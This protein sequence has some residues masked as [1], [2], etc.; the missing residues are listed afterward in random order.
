MFSGSLVAIVT[1]MR[2]DGAVDFA[3]W[4]RLAR[5]SPRRTAPTASSSGARRASRPPQGSGAAGADGAR[6]RAGQRRIPD[7][8]GRGHEQHG[9]HGGAH[10]LAV[11][12]AGRR[13]AGRHAGL[14]PPAAGRAVSATSRRSWKPSRVPVILYNIP[15]RTAVDLLPATVARLVQLPGHR[16]RQRRCCERRAACASSLALAPGTSRVL[17]GDDATSR[18]AVLAG[19][20][21]VISVTA[22][23]APRRD[24]G[25][26]AAG[27]RGRR[28]GRR[29]SWTRSSRHCIG[30]CS[31]K[32]IPF[33]SNG[34]WRA[35]G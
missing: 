10:A 7:H 4:E 1:P 13:A 19:A 22:N 6:L 24:V 8:R 32:P 3:A 17:S 14:Q 29:A 34:R 12:A 15:C 11:R 28:R 27:A 23:V 2:P 5:F 26:G 31:S 25:Y 18:E 21:G 9:H 33:R 16:R 30:I 35:W 20:K